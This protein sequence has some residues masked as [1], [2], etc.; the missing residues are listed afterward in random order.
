M[1]LIGNEH[2]FYQCEVVNLVILNDFGD[3]WS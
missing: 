2:A 1:A 3:V